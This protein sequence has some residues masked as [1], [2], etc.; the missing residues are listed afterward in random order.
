MT[1]HRKKVC[2]DCGT[3]Y[4]YQSSGFGADDNNDPMWCLEC[5]AIINK[6]RKTIKPKFKYNWIEST[7]YSLDELKQIE[8]AYYEKRNADPTI[9]FPN[10]RRVFAGLIDFSDFANKNI[11]SEVTTPNGI[12]HYSH[13]TKHGDTTISKR[14]YWDIVND[15]PSDTQP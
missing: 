6:V 15:K 11:V 8:T 12:F 13:W 3:I 2:V 1:T 10:C 7:E 9:L 14:I 4:Y 5:A